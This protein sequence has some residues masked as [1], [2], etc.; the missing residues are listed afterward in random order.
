MDPYA[1]RQHPFA[2]NCAWQL[3]HLEITRPSTNVRGSYRRSAWILQEQHLGLEEF[4]TVFGMDKVMFNAM[5]KWKQVLHEGP[6]AVKAPSGGVPKLTVLVP[7]TPL[8]P[9]YCADECWHVNSQTNA[10]KKANLY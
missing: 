7:V 4:Q 8:A 9:V 6:Y 1:A 3:P 5:P 10:K 2:R